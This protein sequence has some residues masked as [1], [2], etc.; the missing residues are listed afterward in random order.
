MTTR[1]INKEQPKIE[2]RSDEVNDILR[3]PPRWIIRWGISVITLILLL[4]IAGSVIFKYPD[5]ITAP[6]IINSE[7]MPVRIVAKS[8]G[9]MTSF[10][11][12]ENQN[13]KRNQLMAVIENPA[14]YEDYRVLKDLCDSLSAV[15]TSVNSDAFF[16][17]KIT[18]PGRLEVGM[19]QNDFVSLSATLSEFSTFLQND[20]HR[21]K[22]EKIRSQIGY[23]RNQVNSAARKLKM[24]DE[25]KMLTKRNFERDS[26]LFGQKVISP[27]DLEKSRGALLTVFQEYENLSNSMNTLQISIQQ[28]EQTIFDL[29]QERSRSVQE[30]QR[31]LKGNLENLKATMA[32]WEQLYLL[33]SPVDG[34]V[35]L[36][37]YW[38]ENQNIHTGDVVATVIPAGETKIFGKIF[39][40]LNGAGKVKIGQR[41]NI[42]VDNYPYLEYGMLRETVEQISE[43]PAV[44]DNKNVYVVTVRFPRKL[45]T[46]FN[47]EIPCNQ[48]MTG[49]AEIITN[50]ISILKRLIFPIRH[51]I[52]KVT[53]S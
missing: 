3:R 4:L 8:N 10:L 20:Y 18:V 30:Y 28:A 7:N 47:T 5:K 25:Q 35:S 51:L 53:H 40:P 22:I 15:A 44:I 27:A 6:I 31:N 33:A 52:D 21:K 46:G 14:K 48:E 29:E 26:I 9:R 24:A 50:D 19:M 34:R 49:Q 32:S 1:D 12:K 13:V 17:K 16:L 43:V 2:L 23:Q 11:V 37:Q 45:L 36:S 39:L 42:K 38:K 41:V